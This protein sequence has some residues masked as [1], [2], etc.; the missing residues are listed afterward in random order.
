M[1]KIRFV[2]IIIVLSV[3]ILH[4][5]P[6]KPKPILFVHGIDGDSKAWGVKPMYKDTVANGKNYKITR[7]TINKDSIMPGDSMIL[8]KC[9]EKLTPIVWAWDTLG[10]DTT[11]TI[12]GRVTN[13][14]YPDPAYPNKT[15]LEIINFDDNSGSVNPK[16]SW[17]DRYSSPKYKGEG[18][19]LA[20]RIRSVQGEQTI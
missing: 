1:K 11:Y 13:Y 12:P 9:L 3:T 15:F 19:E 18:Q 10:Y 8:P 14:P 6:Y 16:G 2:I 7:D 20:A 17:P 5:E 4:A